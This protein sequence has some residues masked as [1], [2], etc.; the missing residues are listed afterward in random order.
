MFKILYRFISRVRSCKNVILSEYASFLPS[1]NTNLFLDKS[2]KIIINGGSF[3]IG[4]SSSNQHYS[5]YA[6][7]NVS[8][9][10][11]AEIHVH[12]DCVF[13]PGT[14]I[15]VK[16]NAKLIIKGNNYFAHNTMIICGQR[17][18]IGR[19]TLGSWGITLIDNDG[20]KFQSKRGALFSAKIN[21]L[22]IGNNVGIQSKV[23]IPA[24]VTIGDNAVLSTGTILR[25]SVP[26]NSHAYTDQKLVIKSTRRMPAASSWS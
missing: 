9:E 11:G 18:E 15:K 21:P 16:K 20:H 14:T 23:I 13:G 1:R 19:G 10:A 24:G 7:S 8:L 6:E 22:I 12:G 5:S 26:E 4:E 3:V 2:S 25:A 17:I